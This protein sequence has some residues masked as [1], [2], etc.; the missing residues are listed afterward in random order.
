MNSHTFACS[1]ALVLLATPRP[2][3]AQDKKA[4]GSRPAATNL[5]GMPYPRIHSDLRL[6]FQVKAPSADKVQLNFGLGKKIYEMTRGDGDVWTVTTPPVVPGFYFYHFVIGGVLVSDP[7]SESFYGNFRQSSAIDVPA[8]GVDFYDNKD[9][10]HGDVRERWYRSKVTGQQRRAYIYTPPGYEASPQMRYPVLYLQHGSGGD[11]RQWTNQGHANF[12]LDNLI[13]AGKA[14]PMIVVTE[15]G[16]A[17]RTPGGGSKGTGKGGGNAFEDVVVKDLIPMIDANYRTNP[18]RE[19]RAI[20]GLSM[21]GSQALQIGLT[22]L[23]LFSA[24]G[25]FSGSVGKMDLTK[26]YGGVFADA[27]E[28]NKKVSVLYL[29]AGTAEEA[30]HKNTLAFHNSLEKAGIRSIFEDSKGTGH[31]WSTWRFGFYKLA[32]RLFQD[33]AKE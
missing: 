33:S 30:L 31:E 29:Q 12:I 21:G 5:S 18:N 19:Y 32:P 8:P 27:A 10:P 14:K 16:Y 4:D 28:F 17:N 3:M 22:H 11:E 25:E 26:A 24:I 1:A 15:K 7:S 6:T 23:D 2:A 13:A 20:A 9:V